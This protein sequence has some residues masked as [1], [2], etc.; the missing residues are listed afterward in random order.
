MSEPETPKKIAYLF[1]AG[2]THAEIANHEE[3]PQNPKFL[4]KRG[5]LIKS[6][7]NRVIRKAN[8]N[9]KYL[10]NIEM[11][12]SA[13]GDPNIELLLSLIEASRI[14]DWNYKTTYLKKLVREDIERVLL[15]YKP[16]DFYLHKA[17]IE[18]HEHKKT[19][20]REKL[21]A[22]ISL[23]YDDILDK[24]YKS[25]KGDSPNYSFL[26]DGD[27]TTPLL[28]IHGSFNW[29]DIRM[30]GKD[31]DIEIIPLGANKNYI[32]IPY[33]FI[34]NRA[35][36]TL[37]ECDILRVI[38]S[39]LSQNDIHLIDLLFK[40]HLERGAPIQIQIIS[41][42]ETGDQI[43]RNYSFF[44]K[45]ETISEIEPPLIPGPAEG[46]LNPFKTWLFHKSRSVLGE[47]SIKRTK[48]LKRLKL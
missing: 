47:R 10:E 39:S 12:S 33:N 18:F 4:E 22:L 19:K 16:K 6:V 35:L 8:K 26:Q 5:L 17:L 48:H 23:N 14:Q 7:S 29:R 43:R 37:I 46:I 34:W 15:K 38:G 32:H 24:A 44:S 3:D 31:R 36:E 20:K 41:S 9:K 45:I 1:G 42:E 30:R 28:K 40:A 27:K 21:L 25:V 13:K 11:V 2:S